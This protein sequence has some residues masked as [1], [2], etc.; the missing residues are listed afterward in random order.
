MANTVH[1]P[2]HLA[3]P[4][5]S[6]PKQL[7]HLHAQ[8]HWG[9]TATGKKKKKGLHLCTQSA[10]VL[11]SSATLWTVAWQA[12]LSQGFSRQESWSGLPDPSQFS[13]VAELCSTLCDPM[14]CSTPDFPVYQQLLEFAQTHVHQVGD[15]IQLSPLSSPSPPAFNLSQHQGL[16]Q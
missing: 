5:S 13:S 14:D 9:R 15:D 3:L 11:S 6:G 10:S 16:F 4:G 12:S 2:V 7:R 8:P 1:V